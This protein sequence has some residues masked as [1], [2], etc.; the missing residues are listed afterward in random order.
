M[1]SIEYLR[2]KDRFGGESLKALEIDPAPY[3]T[4]K[5]DRAA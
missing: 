4:F 1:F 3:P 5:V 2:V